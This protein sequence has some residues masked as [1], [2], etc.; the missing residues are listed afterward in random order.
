MSAITKRMREE[1]KRIKNVQ[2]FYTY[3][4]RVIRPKYKPLNKN[5]KLKLA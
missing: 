5:E 1:T 3:L 4:F 2:L